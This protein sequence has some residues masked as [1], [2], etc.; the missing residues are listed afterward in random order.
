ML[1]DRVGRYVPLR[2][3]GRGGTGIV[4]AAHDP[5]LDRQVAIKLVHPQVWRVASPEERDLLRQ[6]ARAMARLVHP[7]VVAVHD[8]GTVGEQLFVAMELVTGTPLDAWLEA[9][10]RAWREVL[11]VCRGSPRRARPPR[12]QGV[13][14]DRRRA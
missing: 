2:V 4:I 13:E 5:E 10:P 8:L 11:A 12:H 9:K 14:R 6:E 7:N 1:G 3:I